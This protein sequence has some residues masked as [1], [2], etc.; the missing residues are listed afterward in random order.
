[1]NSIQ[2]RHESFKIKA[3]TAREIK[4]MKFP[5]TERKIRQL[6]FFSNIQSDLKKLPAVILW[7]EK[8]YFFFWLPLCLWC[9]NC[10]YYLQFLFVSDIYFPSAEM[11]ISKHIGKPGW[12][13]FIFLLHNFIFHYSLS[14]KLSI[15]NYLL[16]YQVRQG[17]VLFLTQQYTLLK[18]IWTEW[19]T[20]I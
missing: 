5:L 20:L 16:T 15:W 8:M 6:I 1:M 14:L 4:V 7:L 19:K 10:Y 12:N 9:I 11:N 17:K 18:E 3:D 13:A 2:E